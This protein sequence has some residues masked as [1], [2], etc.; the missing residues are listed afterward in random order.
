MHR[1][2][3]RQPYMHIDM[4]VPDADANDGQ[5]PQGKVSNQLM[6]TGR[7]GCGE[8]ARTDV[9]QQGAARAGGPMQGNRVRNFL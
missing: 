3:M 9:V 4:H 6:E 1:M 7:T 5:A 8:E 2:L